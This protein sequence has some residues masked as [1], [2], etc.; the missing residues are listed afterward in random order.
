VLGEGSSAIH[1]YKNVSGKFEEL[2]AGQTGLKA[3]GKAV[4]CAVG[5]YD[6]DGRPDLAVAMSDRVILFHNLG[7]GK[8]ADVT[9]AV[10]IETLN[11]PSGLTF[12]DYDHD[13]DVD[14]FVTGTS[15]G[16][17]PNVLWRNNGN[18]TFTE[19]TGPTGL[20]GT[21]A[22]TAVTLSD[23]NNDRAVD[24]IVTGS[25]APVIYEN[26]REGAFKAVPLY[27]DAGLAPSRG[28]AVFD[29]NKDGWMAEPVA[30]C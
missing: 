6:A 21:G 30:Q 29:F 7:G 24:L 16:H 28:V 2:S 27:T 13:G 15:I 26:Q 17:G 18:S 8:F 5:D 1:A 19:W 23:I 9:K 3:S 14:L 4:A 10:G 22:T 25:G 20:A 11:R 12:V